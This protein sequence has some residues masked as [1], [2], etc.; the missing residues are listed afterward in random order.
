MPLRGEGS[1]PLP[2]RLA[3]LTLLKLKRYRILDRKS[4]TIGRLE[5]SNPFRGSNQICAIEEIK[6][7]NSVDQFA[8]PRNPERPLST[9]IDLENGG[10][11]VGVG[12]AA[13]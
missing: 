13:S 10:K 5:N 8:D 1:T 3:A 12:K 7:R 9:D 6:N 2:E 4:G 11:L